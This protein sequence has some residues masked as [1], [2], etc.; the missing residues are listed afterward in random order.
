MQVTSSP[1]RNILLAICGLFACGLLLSAEAA[2]GGEEADGS[3]TAQQGAIMTS[4][5][6]S[7]V[8]VVRFSGILPN[9]TDDAEG[10]VQRELLTGVLGMTF[11]LYSE[12][13][14]GAPLWLETQT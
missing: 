7:S 13:R 8:R 4:A 12:Q 3:P 9:A 5:A 11:A 6:G 14:G 10:G 1:A 2:M